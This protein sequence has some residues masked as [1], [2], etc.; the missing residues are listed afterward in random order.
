MKSSKMLALPSSREGFGMVVLE[1]KACGLPV[2]TVNEPRNAARHLVKDGSGDK[3]TEVN[4]ESIAK[5]ILEL[6]ENR[7]ATVPGQGIERYDWRI[8]TAEVEDAFSLSNNIK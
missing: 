4:P 6:L 5:G 3:V 1:A 8:I 2:L 7:A